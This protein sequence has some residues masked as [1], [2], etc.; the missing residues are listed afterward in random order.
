[1]LSPRVFRLFRQLL[2]LFARWHSGL[3]WR[4]GR[5]RSAT[6]SV[7][8]AR[9][10]PRTSNAPRVISRGAF[11]VFCMTLFCM[12][13]ILVFTRFGGDLLSHVLRRSTIG[14]EALNGRVRNGAGCFALAMT[15]KPRKNHDA[16]QERQA[17][18]KVSAKPITCSR[19]PRL[20]RYNQHRR[21]SVVHVLCMLVSV[22][23]GCPTL[24]LLD[25]IKPIGPLVPVN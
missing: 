3:N 22:T 16:P 4:S 7:A 5:L 23:V 21:P 8:F 12:E 17:G 11:C 6:R 1:M 9:V 10:V 15:T 13:R 14:A 2:K 25:Q 18:G 19:T 24:L 20:E